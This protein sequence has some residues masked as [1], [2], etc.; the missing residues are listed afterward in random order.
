MIDHC[1]RQHTGANEKMAS[2]LAAP[3]GRRRRTVLR[4]AKGRSLGMMGGHEITI[5]GPRWRLILRAQSEAARGAGN[6]VKRR[7]KHH[8]TFG[9]AFR[10]CVCV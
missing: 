8:F 7:Q 3:L 1:Q 10:V 5:I 9:L 4:L 2:R 6:E